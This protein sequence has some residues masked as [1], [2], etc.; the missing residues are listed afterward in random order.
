M[1]MVGGALVAVALVGGG[2]LWGQQHKVESVRAAGIWA[3]HCLYK[4]DTRYDSNGS[5][6]LEAIVWDDDDG[7]V[8][9]YTARQTVSE[10]DCER[11]Y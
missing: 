6:Y 7:F 5:K 10:F 4:I 2:Y 9:E 11:V 8:T 3:D 1:Q